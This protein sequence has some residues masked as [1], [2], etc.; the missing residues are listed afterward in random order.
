M[1]TLSQDVCLLL[2]CTHDLIISRGGNKKKAAP[3]EVPS[4]VSQATQSRL[5]L[6]DEQQEL[7]VVLKLL[8]RLREEIQSPLPGQSHSCS[9][10]CSCSSSCSSSSSSSAGFLAEFIK[11][12]AV[13]QAT[14]SRQQRRLLQQVVVARKRLS[15]CSPLV[16][17]RGVG[18][19][20][21]GD[22]SGQ[23]KRART[24]QPRPCGEQT[25]RVVS[26]DGAEQEQIERT[27]ASKKGIKRKA[28]IFQEQQQKQ[29]KKQKQSRLWVMALL[30]TAK[31]RK[32]CARVDQEMLI[33]TAIQF[34]T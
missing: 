14:L 22:G 33:P 30:D 27:I 13:C 5:L 6:S 26:V 7:I 17:Q 18:G 8:Y 24:D 31:R 10:S 1:K 29:T 11:V 12:V 9:C 32:R 20:R 23:Q 4:T 3:A 16:Q 25:E 19:G 15:C 2:R 28:E 21:G 34:R